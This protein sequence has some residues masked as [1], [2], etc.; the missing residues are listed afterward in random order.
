MKK[1]A[2]HSSRPILRRQESMKASY[3]YQPYST[4]SML[5][6]T[7]QLILIDNELERIKPERICNLTMKP[8]HIRYSFLT[9][10]NPSY[11]QHCIV[12]SIKRK[13]YLAC[14]TVSKYGQEKPTLEL[15][16]PIPVLSHKTNEINFENNR[17]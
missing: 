15:I 13:D 17:F 10:E 8:F 7:I 14:L 1:Y 11:A 9:R 3:L 2:K 16:D 6:R 12:V 5:E 4:M